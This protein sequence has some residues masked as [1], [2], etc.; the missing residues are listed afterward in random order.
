MKVTSINPGKVFHT[1]PKGWTYT[2]SVNGQDQSV[3]D[4]YYKSA[5]DAKQAMRENVAWLRKH[6]GVQK[7]TK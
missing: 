1:A 6:H 4:T 3:G 7:S 2:V 5:G